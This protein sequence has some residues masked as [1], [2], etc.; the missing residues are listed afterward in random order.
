[1]KRDPIQRLAL[2]DE[3]GNPA[4][5]DRSWRFAAPALALTLAWIVGWYWSTGASIVAIWARSET[6]AHGFVVLPITLWLVWRMREEVM[7]I[8]PRPCGWFALPLLA[9][10][11][12]WLLGELGTVNALSQ[13]AFVAMLVLAVPAVLGVTVAR[14]IA[15]PLGF[16]FFAVPVGEFVMPQ[17]MEWTAN[18]TVWALGISGIPV[19]REGQNFVI[20]SG[21]WSVVEACSGVRYLIASLVIGTLYAY[22]T[23]RST[24]R[25]LGFIAVAIAV[26]IV[27]NWARA[28][29]IVMIGHLSGNTL[30]VGVDHL[31]YGWIF[32]GAVILL[33]FWIGGRWREPAVAAPA[34]S[35]VGKSVRS[36]ATPFSF[37]GVA[38]AIAVATAIWPA[39]FRAIERAD[40][41]PAPSLDA[42]ASAGAWTATAGG[43]GDWR[44]QFVD[45]STELHQTFRRGD[46]TVGVYVGYFR[47]QGPRRKLVSSENVLVRSDD[48]AWMRVGNGVRQIA[49]DAATV[50]A[51]TAEL[52][53]RSG[54]RLVAWYWYWIDGRLTSSDARAKAYTALSRI[55]G[56]GDDGAIVVVYAPKGKP[57]TAEAAMDA[58]LTDVG[59][60]L[61]ARLKETRDRR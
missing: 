11:G 37:A 39:G 7:Q 34:G 36:T 32:F 53:N 55:A 5:A 50:D 45:P 29:M 41:T 38:I 40:T 61:A 14:S 2:P 16:L 12:G 22:L 24:A 9:A 10:G 4:S 42:P 58:F 52:V 47:N 3:A 60:S 26:P 25:R 48:A 1:M 54:D 13:F 27:A 17:L 44:P 20:P 23:Y 59:P 19:F 30:A 49:F 28:Y 35:K 15:F 8:A 21:R 18:V 46:A 51:R 57:G 56:R 33:M 31:I 43:L 6:F